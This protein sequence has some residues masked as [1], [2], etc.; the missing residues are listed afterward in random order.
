MGLIYNATNEKQHVVVFGNHF[1]L[2]AGKI[3]NFQDHISHYIATERAEFGLV[4][5]PEQFEDPDFS[6]SEEGKKILAEKKEEGLKRYI[7]RLKTIA[8]NN[9][10]SLKQDLEKANLKVDSR[11]FATDAELDAMELLAKYQASQDDKVEK[12]VQRIKELEAKI[13]RIEK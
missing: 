11:S 12:K 8:Y 13:G 1:Q 9:L 2:E 3:K 5:L 6:K 10:V 4:S 7:G